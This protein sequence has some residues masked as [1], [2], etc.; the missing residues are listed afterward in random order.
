[1]EQILTFRLIC[2]F[3]ASF[4]N[5]GTV[6]VH[7]TYPFPPPTT[8]YGMLNAARGRPQDWNADRDDWQIAIV[9]ESEGI[10][11]ETFSKVKKAA[12]GEEEGL[13][14]RTTI[15]RQKL[16]GVSYTIYLKACW[17]LLIEAQNAVMDPCWPLYLGE[18]DDAVDVVAPH[19]VN[20]EPEPVQNI[21]SIIPGVVEGCRLLKVPV[22]FHEKGRRW[23]V[24]YAI[25]SLP[26][27]DEGVHLE[28]P[29]PAYSVEG[30]NVVF[31]GRENHTGKAKPDV[32]WSSH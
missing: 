20:A 12:R 14:G 23:S 30:R 31:N 25:Y 16:I 26:P 15:I 8:L 18:S 6:N 13:F 21:H 4:R 10:L 9:V 7:V 29:L 2:P 17:D 24:D 28:K 19:I 11:V 3:W 5:P 22:R 32:I 1:M 27:M